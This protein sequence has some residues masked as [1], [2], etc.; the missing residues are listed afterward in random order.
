[1][2]SFFR[3]NGVALSIICFILFF[4][5][6]WRL[7]RSPL[8]IWDEARVG[9]NALEIDGFRKVIAP[10]YEGKPDM[11]SLKPPLLPVLQRIC[12]EIA[13][14]NVIGV[15]LPSALGVL[16]ICF[17]FI[18]FCY[19]RYGTLWPGII[20]SFVLTTAPGFM[21]DHIARTGDYDALLSFFMIAYALSY[22]RF[23]ESAR[24]K[25]LY[26]AGTAVILG[27]LTKGVAALIPLPG[28]LIYTLLVRKGAFVFRNKSLYIMAGLFVL[29][30]AAVYGLREYITPGYLR[31]V[32]EGEFITIPT[33]PLANHGGPWWFY[34]DDI[35]MTGF[36]YFAACLLLSIISGF[37]GPF[38]D[39][40]APY[41]F[42]YL[43]T[44]LL[45]I[46]AS[47]TKTHW[48]EAPFY[49]AAALAAGI[50]I[51]KALSYFSSYLAKT[52]IRNLAFMCVSVAMIF[53]LP[54]QNILRYNRNS[55]LSDWDLLK[56]GHYMKKIKRE[57]PT[58]NAYT[59]LGKDYNPQS[60]FFAEAFA[61]DGLKTVPKN[62]R[63]TLAVGE[64]VLCCER[65]AID[66]LKKTY[67]FTEI[68]QAMGCVLVRITG[69]NDSLRRAPF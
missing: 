45:V 41:L 17:L 34:I 19:R 22:F 43:L 48:Y 53:A 49:P 28:L 29:I 18:G 60:L 51:Y 54:Y 5:I 32:F 4:P 63:D 65:N 2:L 21:R 69:Q 7:D 26:L 9:V 56:Y 16:G 67:T 10:Y 57:M 44:Y 11:F 58:Y 1:M 62:V 38:R 33:T 36:S 23:L 47:A 64:T 8:S 50:F 14:Y 6:F 61:K 39:T 59:V 30:V 66:D 3:K 40:L 46:S 55:P 35:L 52:R 24:K 15:R 31:L 27:V 12:M 13:G 37:R 25:Y 68:H 20:A 42:T